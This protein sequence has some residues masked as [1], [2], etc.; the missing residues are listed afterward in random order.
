MMVG[1]QSLFNHYK[2]NSDLIHLNIFS[3]SELDEMIPFEREVYIQLHNST[4]DKK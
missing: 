3:L 1:E 4:V 2:T